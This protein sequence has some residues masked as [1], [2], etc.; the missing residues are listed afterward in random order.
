MSVAFIRNSGAV[1]TDQL[2]KF[3]PEGSVPPYDRLERSHAGVRGLI[4]EHLTYMLPR[5]QEI[6]RRDAR[7]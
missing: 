7:T 5:L 2:V 3:P 4:R 6:M 1:A